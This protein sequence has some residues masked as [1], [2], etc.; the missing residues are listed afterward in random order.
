[1]KYDEVTARSG[2]PCPAG[3]KV[4]CCELRP[5]ASHRLPLKA[6]PRRFASPA[7]SG[8]GGGAEREARFNI[9]SSEVELPDCRLSENHG[10]IGFSIR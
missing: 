3:N 6:A 1:M 5:R 10:I 8:H 2:G 7:M 9:R 4:A